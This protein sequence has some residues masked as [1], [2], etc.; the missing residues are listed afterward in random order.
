MIWGVREENALYRWKY[1]CALCLPRIRLDLQ[2]M[3]ARRGFAT[4]ALHK[5][6]LDLLRESIFKALVLRKTS[7][8]GIII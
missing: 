2:S 5:Q 8:T 6:A 3:R 1:G 4:Y 7:C